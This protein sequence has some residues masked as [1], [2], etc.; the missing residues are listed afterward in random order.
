MANTYALGGSPL[1]LINVKSRPDR[2]G[3]STFNGGKSR[4]IN[5]FSYNRGVPQPANVKFGGKEAYAPLSILSGGSFPT[6]WPNADIGKL[7]TEYPSYG[8]R[9]T[10]KGKPYTPAKGTGI[11]SDFHNDGAYDTSVLNVL[12]KLSKTKS[13]A[14]KPQ[15]FAYCKYLGVYPN[16]RLMIARRF[17]SPSKDNIFG[18]S[19]SAPKAVLISWKPEG[20]DFLEFSFGEEWMDAD[21]DFTNVLNKLG[22]DF[23][24]DNAG[25]GLSKAINIIP[26][27]GFTEQLQR[28]ILFGMGILDNKTSQPLPSGNPNLIKIAKRRKTIGYGEAGAGL[29]ATISVKMDCEYEQKF[30][31]GID[32]SNAWLD[33][34]NNVMIFGTSN[35]TDYGLSAKF[36]AKLNSWMDNPGLLVKAVIDAVRAAVTA[37][38]ETISTKAQEALKTLN[39][40]INPAEEDKR[41]EEEKQAANQKLVD[42]AKAQITKFFDKIVNAAY[43]T[44]SKY[45]V[46]IMGIANALSGSPSTP[47]HITLGNPIRPFF[48]SG[49]MY[50]SQDVTVKFGPQLAFNDLPSSIKVGFTLQNAR[51]LGMQEILAKFNMGSLRTVNVKRDFLDTDLPEDESTIGSAL[52]NW[53]TSY[54]DGAFNKEGDALVPPP[55]QTNPSGTSVSTAGVLEINTSNVPPNNFSAEIA[56]LPVAD[57]YVLTGGPGGG[58]VLVDPNLPGTTGSNQIEVFVIGT[59]STGEAVVTT[60]TQTLKDNGDVVASIDPQAG[61]TPVAGFDPSQSLFGGN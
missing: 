56:T 45:K 39:E 5:V 38:K 40:A 11:S 24:I 13:A 54:F 2:T 36:E 30:I 47:W 60:E 14:L 26:L 25:Q 12:E 31:S 52:E 19:G 8:I 41:T 3:Q 10:G 32:P 7:G 17:A 4:N 53:Q 43:K 57:Q 22:K 9:D 44:I 21:A 23:G 59:T 61:L 49:D 18:K 16:N 58:P 1:G 42:K 46:E 55:Q 34:L 27:P 35:S 20:E 48:C 33:I 51:P 6:F 37:I 29:K 50:I 28:E 15:D